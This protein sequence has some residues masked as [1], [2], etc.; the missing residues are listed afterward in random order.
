MLQ[1][2]HTHPA[3]NTDR[4]TPSDFQKTSQT[5]KWT[6][7]WTTESPQQKM[8]DST[9]SS[10]P[11]SS[12]RGKAGIKKCLCPEKHQ[13]CFNTI[14]PHQ[15]PCCCCRIKNCVSSTPLKHPRASKHA[16]SNTV[17]PNFHD[18]RLLWR[19]VICTT[20]GNKNVFTRKLWT[21]LSNICAFYQILSYGADIQTQVE[22]G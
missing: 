18:N 5:K 22:T 13:K 1:S 15:V 10:Q 17:C 2:H 7:A 14:W 4:W 3:S 8:G 19:G 20:N 9:S 6:I 16:L 12:G 21:V 11:S